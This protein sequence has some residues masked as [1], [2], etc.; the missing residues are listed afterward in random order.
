MH[1][2]KISNQ[3]I[4]YLSFLMYNSPY[5]LHYNEYQFQRYKK[6]TKTCGRWCA[7]RLLFKFLPLDDFKNLI[8]ELIKKLKINGDELVTLLTMH[9]NKNVK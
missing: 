2:R 5:D 8:E 6:N 4:P 9:I 1:F 3:D 7:I